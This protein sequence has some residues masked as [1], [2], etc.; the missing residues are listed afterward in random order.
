[1]EERY[2]AA[3]K[4]YA[5]SNNELKLNINDTIYVTKKHESGWWKGRNASNNTGWFPATYFVKH[6]KPIVPIAFSEEK[7][8]LR[9]T[10]P[11]SLC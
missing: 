6:I 7:T 1:M 4:Y 10:V 2:T 3:A 8:V 5:N 11:A 9:L